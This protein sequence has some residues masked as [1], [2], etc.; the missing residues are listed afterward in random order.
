MK[1]NKVIIMLLSL[2]LL[3]SIVPG[4]GATAAVEAS[5]SSVPAQ[6]SEHTQPTSITE[7]SNPGETSELTETS[8]PTETTTSVETA[9]TH[10][11]SCTDDCTADGCVCTCHESSLFEQLMAC[12]SLD[13][14]FTIVDETS[15]ED[16]LALTEQENALIEAKISELE[17][18]PLPA[19]II[20]DTQD[21]PVV[22]EIIYP[23]VN[24]DNVAPFG[25]PVEG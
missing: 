13:E 9:L 3:V 25:D 12:T 5:E 11:E 4:T 1:K 20:E 7:T 2:T 21:E 18:D 17:P 22:S 16:L 23:T 8:E 6:T 10:T 14:L 24:F 15:E 19:V